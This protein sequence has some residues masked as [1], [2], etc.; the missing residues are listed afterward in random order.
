MSSVVPAPSMPMRASGPTTS[1]SVCIPLSQPTSSSRSASSRNVNSPHGSVMIRRCSPGRGPDQPASFA[2]IF[3]R[4]IGRGPS[5]SIQAMRSGR[6]GSR[7]PHHGTPAAMCAAMST[8]QRRL[9]GAAVAVDD[10][11]A[12]GRD[13][14][15]Q[16]LVRL[17]GVDERTGALLLNGREL[18]ERFERERWRA[19]VGGVAAGE[20]VV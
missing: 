8:S 6:T 16:L 19:A 13:H 3:A 20:E 14:S 2:S 1:R 12:A 9:A 4:I 5:F 11:C 15:A 10:D 17:R 18:L 7:T